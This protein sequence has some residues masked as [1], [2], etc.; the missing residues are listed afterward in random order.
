[1]LGR[2]WAQHVLSQPAP[3]PK[4]HIV[5]NGEEKRQHAQ[6]DKNL[7]HIAALRASGAL[8]KPDPNA[9]TT[10]APLR[11]VQPASSQT[12]GNQAA[13]ASALPS[14]KRKSADP[15]PS[16]RSVVMN[17]DGSVSLTPLTVGA[18]AAVDPFESRESAA[19]S[20]ARAKRARLAEA[21]GFGATLGDG[22]SAAAQA[23]TA[24]LL[25]AKTTSAHADL[26]VESDSSKAATEALYD[27]LE[28]REALAVHMNGITEVA[29]S[30]FRCTHP[31]CTVA[32]SEFPLHGCRH[33]GHRVEKVQLNKRF[34]AC[35]GCKFR[36]AYVGAK[37]PSHACHKCGGTVWTRIS[38]APLQVES[39]D[40]TLLQLKSEETELR[41]MFA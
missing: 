34:F 37:L 22:S 20:L 12:A 31:G 32:P 24:R 21:F 25:S 10:R 38:M 11:L 41:T 14:N 30:A 5:L 28:K 4:R 35:A 1:M 40:R 27:Y 18:T 15:A 2:G 13:A 26:V 33:K 8:A 7:Q 36:V 16:A 39:S 29:V 19:E 23:E 6:M 17:K 3:A 9:T